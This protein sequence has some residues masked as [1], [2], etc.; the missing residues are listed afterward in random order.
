MVCEY[1][2]LTREQMCQRTAGGQLLYGLGSIAIHA[3][4]VE[5]PDRP[6]IAADVTG[7]LRGAGVNINEFFGTVQKSSV[8][9][10]FWLES[11]ADA[12]K[13]AKAVQAVK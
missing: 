8:A 4:R 11:K 3:V 1:S 5:S 2:D 13:V 7:A 9:A 12:A 6:G 10:Y